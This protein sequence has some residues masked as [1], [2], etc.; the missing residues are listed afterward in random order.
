MK[1]LNKK[2]FTLVELLVV[3]VIIVVIMS[4]AIPSITSSLERSKEKQRAAI[5]K[6]VISA[7][8]LYIDRYKNSYSSCNS[9][10]VCKISIK[11]LISDNLLSKEES[12]DPFN[13]NKTLCGWVAYNGTDYS[14]VKDENSIECE[15]ID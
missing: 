8:E 5:E 15:S 7:G 3:L 9:S 12:K 14:W 2:G 10:S 11:T 4:I 13:E 1:R 6:L